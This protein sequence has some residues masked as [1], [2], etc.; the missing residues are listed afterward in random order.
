[1][2]NLIALKGPSQSGKSTLA[3]LLKQAYKKRGRTVVNTSLGDFVRAEIAQYIHRNDFR[4]ESM[5]VSIPPLSLK[6]T[7]FI[8]VPYWANSF[9]RHCIDYLEIRPAS[10]ESRQLQQLW[11]T[12]FRRAQDP[13]YWIKKSC[14]AN[15]GHLMTSNT[16]V[17]EESCRHANEG[18]YIRALGGVVI[19]LAPLEAPTPSELVHRSH[20]IEQAT[21]QWKGD[22]K[23]DMQDF[24][25]DLGRDMGIRA[26]ALAG[27]IEKFHLKK[28]KASA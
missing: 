16:I 25:V 17:I 27:E 22:I 18:A 26:L 23:V 1:M 8:E 5:P 20:P 9:E 19:D 10:S 13:L 14:A 7:K 2:L 4:D 6:I 11:G 3:G 21:F 28:Q 12:N 24:F 15:I